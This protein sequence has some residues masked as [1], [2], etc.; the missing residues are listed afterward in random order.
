MKFKQLSSSQIISKEDYILILVSTQSVLK[1]IHE[2]SIRIYIRQISFIYISPLVQFKQHPYLEYKK[3][4]DTNTT[5][6][7]C[8]GTLFS[9][10]VKTKTEVYT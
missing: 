1:L 2:F 3:D 5:R 10:R 9:C 8:E 4:K 6:V 7:L